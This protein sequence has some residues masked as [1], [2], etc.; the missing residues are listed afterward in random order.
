MD[1]MKNIAAL[2][3]FFAVLME[4]AVVSDAEPLQVQALHFEQDNCLIVSIQG[5]LIGTTDDLNESDEVS[6]VIYDDGK[7][8]GQ[9]K[10]YLPLDRAV[11]IEEYI[12][13]QG[14]FS[15]KSPGVAVESKEIGLY[16]DPL[17]PQRMPGYC[18][19]YLHKEF[20]EAEYND[21][22]RSLAKFGFICGE[23][24]K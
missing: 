20:M 24:S 1:S 16:I 4:G 23:I 3:I 22:C 6:F 10:L 9:K 18:D 14:N 21:T 5:K 11:K 7:I 8:V 15:Q 17:L 19:D 12:K 2:L 13:L